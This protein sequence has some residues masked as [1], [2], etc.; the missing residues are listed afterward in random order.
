MSRAI[1]NLKQNL[2]HSLE[3]YSKNPWSW[4]LETK[5]NSG[6]LPDTADLFSWFP[7]YFSSDFH[8]GATSGNRLLRGSFLNSKSLEIYLAVVFLHPFLGMDS[9]AWNR[10]SRIPK[11]SLLVSILLVFSSFLLNPHQ[12]K[13]QNISKYPSSII[14]Q[15]IISCG[16]PSRRPTRRGLKMAFSF[17]KKSGCQMISCVST[18]HAQLHIQSRSHQILPVFPITLV[19]AISTCQVSSNSSRVMPP[20]QSLS[21]IEKIWHLCWITAATLQG[22]TVRV[23]SADSQNE[24]RGPENSESST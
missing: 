21:M 20:E 16:L 1:G 10:E 3:E 7:P 19:L 6:A 17:Q 22:K 23:K 11:S 13:Y 18:L 4:N 9:D 24:G 12:W 5:A 2:A 8:E 15:K 14:F